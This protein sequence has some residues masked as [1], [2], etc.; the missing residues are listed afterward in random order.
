M[1]E[2][3]T[4]W[5]LL[6]VFAAA[7]AVVWAGLLV[8]IAWIKLTG[9]LEDRRWRIRERDDWRRSTTLT[10]GLHPEDLAPGRA[11][12]AADVH[13]IPTADELRQWFEMEGGDR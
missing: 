5:H 3:I 10:G 7:L 13:R 11:R 6:L 9:A 4:L 8:W 12:L 1:T 2:L